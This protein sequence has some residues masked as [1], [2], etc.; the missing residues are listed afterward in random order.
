MSALHAVQLQAVVKL[1]ID[2]TNH[3]QID[4][5]DTYESTNFI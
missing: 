1:T 3:K 2:L 4:T 5:L